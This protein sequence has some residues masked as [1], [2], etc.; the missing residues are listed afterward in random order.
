MKYRQIR[1]VNKLKYQKFI[2]LVEDRYVTQIKMS[3]HHR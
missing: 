2:K 1:E 3:V